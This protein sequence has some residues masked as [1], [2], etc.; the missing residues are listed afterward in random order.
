MNVKKKGY[1]HKQ[2]V[3]LL[4]EKSR[5]NI[6]PQQL[7]AWKTKKFKKILVGMEMNIVPQ[8]SRL[9]QASFSDTIFST[10]KTHCRGLR[11]YFN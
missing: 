6:F 7:K 8:L 11:R 10:L 3:L 4:W 5:L 2:V 9:K 1:D